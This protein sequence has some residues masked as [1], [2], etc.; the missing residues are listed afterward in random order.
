[1]QRNSARDAD[2]PAP[3]A[4]ADDRTNFL[5]MEEPRE[6]IA[7]G[8]REFVDDHYLR[9]VNRDRRPWHIFS[10]SRRESRE[11]FA[12]KFLRVEV[13]DLPA[14]V[15]ALVND[16]AVLIDLRGELFVKRDDAGEGG[17]RRTAK[18]G[19]ATSIGWTKTAAKLRKP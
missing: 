3:G 11:K 8:A 14:G 1:M 5:A 16:D 18:P 12:A 4:C 15:V 7:A 9:S 2:E 17:V 6:G 10:F 19:R 13:R